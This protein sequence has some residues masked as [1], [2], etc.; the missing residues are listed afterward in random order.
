[1]PESSLS[2]SRVYSAQPT[3][4]INGRASDKV[5]E[6]LNSMRLTESEGGM[7]SL[8]LRLGNTARFEDGQVGL[9]FE[10]EAIL[11]LGASIA[12]YAGDEN[13][14]R[15]IFRGLVTG[16]EASFEGTEGP[17]LLVLAEDA[18][19]RA[20]LARR[21][22][23]HEDVSI[24]SLARE[25]ATRLGMRPVIT[26]F[27]ERIGT[28]V[29]LNESDLA[30]LRRLLSAHDGDLQ[31]VG[32]ELHVSPRKD[33]R[34]GSV[35]LELYSQLRRAH[36]TVDLAH[37]V[38]EI[39]ASGWDA[40]A[41]RRVSGQ[42]TG[43]SLGPGAGRRGADLLRETLGARSEHLGNVPAMTDE[44]ARAIASAAFD[45]RARRFVCV[46]GTSEGHPSLRVGTHVTLRGLGRRFDNTYYVVRACHRYDLTHG[47]E[48]DFEAEC[49]FLG[50]P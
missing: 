45:Q 41:G 20:R 29:Q 1:M 48:T 12:I 49:A 40:R 17:E 31:V 42:G 24:D 16:L 23:V 19:Q 32:E 39:T 21:T 33:V 7:S 13:A 38:T 3:V 30:F 18:L 6:L 25:L 36:V 14:P 11:R 44:E 22:Q 43:T 26:G 15:E 34:R 47:Y 4:R 27:S 9:A 46:E 5:K 10:D 37:Q 8:E 35:E 50:A 28:Q 2:S